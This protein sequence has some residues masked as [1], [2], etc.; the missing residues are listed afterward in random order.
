MEPKIRQLFMLRTLACVSLCCGCLYDHHAHVCTCVCV[1][2]KAR[3]NLLFGIGYNSKCVHVGI[4]VN[5]NSITIMTRKIQDYINKLIF[6]VTR[7]F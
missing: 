3:L 1:V 7:V 5:A 2:N 6:R 4:W